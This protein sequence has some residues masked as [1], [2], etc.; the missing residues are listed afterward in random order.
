M[1]IKKPAKKPAIIVL[2]AKEL[3]LT[4]R[5]VATLKRLFKTDVTS[6]LKARSRTGD[7]PPFP[8]VNVGGAGV[9]SSK[10]PTK[11]IAQTSSSKKK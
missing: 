6:V 4:S 11:K 8:D 10:K 7:P 1:V 3:K 9:G 5:E 2:V